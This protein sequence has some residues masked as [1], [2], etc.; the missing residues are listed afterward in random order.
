MQWNNLPDDVWIE[1][2]PRMFIVLVGGQSVW[3]ILLDHWA[4]LSLRQIEDKH[5]VTHV[6]ASRWIRQAKV[7]IREAGLNADA[8]KGYAERHETAQSYNAGGA[9]GPSCG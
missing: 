3:E 4:G 6:T 8:I 2:G 9:V 7:K 5:G 1:A